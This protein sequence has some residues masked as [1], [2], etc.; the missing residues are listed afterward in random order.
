MCVASRPSPSGSPDNLIIVAQFA[1]AVVRSKPSFICTVSPNPPALASVL[2]SCVSPGVTLL[3]HVDSDTFTLGLT[4]P[5]LLKGH[6]LSQSALSESILTRYAPS[7]KTTKASTGG[8]K[9]KRCMITADHGILCAVG[10][11]G[12]PHIGIGGPRRSP[13]TGL[14]GRLSFRFYASASYQHSCY[15]CQDGF[16]DAGGC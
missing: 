7:T 6:Y 1:S 4:L 10:F 12:L 8:A 3:Q 13:R 9:H 11:L 2:P 16:T 15:R 5:S 14:W